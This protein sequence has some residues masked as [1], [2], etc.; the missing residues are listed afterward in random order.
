MCISGCAYCAI[1]SVCMKCLHET[2]A[3]E[4]CKSFPTKKDGKKSL[5]SSPALGQ[6]AMGHLCCPGLM[7]QP[8]LFHHGGGLKISWSHRGLNPLMV[9]KNL[10]F[11][12]NHVSFY[13]LMVVLL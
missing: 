13:S 8:W 11:R 6:M 7:F 5:G 3:E 10:V 12:L 9:G 4:L 1:T 2:S